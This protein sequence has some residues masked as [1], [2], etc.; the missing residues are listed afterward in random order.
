MP[1]PSA[2]HRS[3]QDSAQDPPD[4]LCL[5]LLFSGK[6][7]YPQRGRSLL[8]FLSN[9]SRSPENSVL[10]K[11]EGAGCSQTNKEII[12]TSEE[13]FKCPVSCLAQDQALPLIPPDWGHM[14]IG[15][16]SVLCQLLFPQAPCY[17]IIHYQDKVMGTALAHYQTRTLFIVV[18]CDFLETSFTKSIG[19]FQSKR[20]SYM[21][22][23][24]NVHKRGVFYKQISSPS[25]A[26]A[27]VIWL[28][29]K[30]MERGRRNYWTSQK[31]IQLCYGA[32][33][34]RGTKSISLKVSFLGL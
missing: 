33:A 8:L 6:R 28:D 24:F 18:N 1:E 2:S 10:C 20:L 25:F 7:A 11:P 23:P 26:R 32:S 30:Q 12:T 34:P 19:V 22:L 29:M 16:G 17:G 9:S 15:R 3:P 5:Y 21:P 31:C 13:L 4:Q 27:G 14:W